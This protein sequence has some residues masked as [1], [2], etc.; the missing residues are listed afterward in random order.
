MQAPQDAG[1]MRRLTHSSQA[2]AAVSPVHGQT[3]AIIGASWQQ[4]SPARMDL[5]AELTLGRTRLAH[6]PRALRCQG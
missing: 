6:G 2:P 1:H 3:V 4:V 5:R